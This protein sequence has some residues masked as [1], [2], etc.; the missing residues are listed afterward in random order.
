M[1]IDP[2]DPIHASREELVRRK[3]YN[4]YEQR[5]KTEGRAIEDWL[6]A[7]SQIEME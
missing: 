6:Q 3:A 7:E 5:G 1:P 4:L 2:V